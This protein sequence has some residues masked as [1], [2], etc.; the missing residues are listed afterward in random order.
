MQ[1]KHAVG[2][3]SMQ[4]P[5]RRFVQPP[6][7]AKICFR[8]QKGARKIA[9][10]IFGQNLRNRIPTVHLPWMCVS[11]CCTV[12]PLTR[13]RGPT[14]KA[15]GTECSNAVRQAAQ[16]LLVCGG[17]G[18]G[19]EGQGHEEDRQP[20]TALQVAKC[21]MGLRPPPPKRGPLI[22][23]PH[24]HNMPYGPRGMDPLGRQ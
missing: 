10:E 7:G 14:R 18:A 8:P 21:R 15:P 19:R 12:L 17:P 2:L 3:G 13:L 23:R 9:P 11:S 16:C 22:P 24:P 6:D 20:P 1:A 5:P 4:L